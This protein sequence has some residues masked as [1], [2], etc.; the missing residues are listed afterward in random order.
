MRA[1]RMLLAPL[2]I[3]LAIGI[4]PT[5]G[6]DQKEPPD[7]PSGGLA[8]APAET[9]AS[10][11][12]AIAVGNLIELGRNNKMPE[13]LVAAAL[14]LNNIPID[15]IE[16]AEGENKSEPLPTPQS[17]LKEAAGLAGTDKAIG[18][19]VKAAEERLK[20]KER[21]AVGGPIRGFT[22][23]PKKIK[24]EGGKPAHVSVA[25]RATVMDPRTKRV[26]PVQAGTRMVITDAAN[27]VVY[28]SATQHKGLFHLHPHTPS[29]TFHP[30]ATA[31]Y[32]VTVTVHAQAKG[33]KT[34]FVGYTN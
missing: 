24:F 11:D 34:S 31:V 18:E 29:H 17:L 2:A 4:S 25:G 30:K 14:I 13:A 16:G 21:G 15:P 26:V 12:Q 5:R 27:K 9:L 28:D 23:S 8:P 10:I 6:D 7:A 22:D 20:A 19:L 1:Y 33:A 3:A 32:T